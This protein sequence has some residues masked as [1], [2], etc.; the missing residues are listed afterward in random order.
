MKSNPLNQRSDKFT[1]VLNDSGADVFKSA[2]YIVNKLVWHKDLCVIFVAC[3]KHDK[4]FDEET[5]QTKTVHYHVVIHF[6]RNYRVGTV[7]NY[8]S[9][10]FSC[11]ENQVSVDKCNSLD[12]QTRYLI[13]LDEGDDKWHYSEDAVAT[14]NYPQFK[15]SLKIIKSISGV[16]DLI[17]ICRQYK[18]LLELMTIIGFDNYKKY[19]NVI[20]DIRKELNYRL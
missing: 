12:M 2:G 19:R 17:S 15:R 8:F 1:V 9:Q 18:D 6:D 14:N 5:Q 4:D 3:I 10:I 11:N 13:H 16:A 20:N 7:I